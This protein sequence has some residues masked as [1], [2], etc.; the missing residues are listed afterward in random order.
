MKVLVSYKDYMHN[1]IYSNWI[2][3]IDYIWLYLR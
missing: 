3:N 1:S 2:G